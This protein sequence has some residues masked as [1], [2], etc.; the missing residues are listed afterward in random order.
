LSVDNE[1]GLDDA[2]VH[3]QEG[4]LGF[5]GGLVV[6]FVAGLLELSDLTVNNLGTLSRTDTVAED[7]D[8]SGEGALVFSGED[9]DSL[10]HAILDLRVDYLLS[11]LLDDKVRVI[12]RHLLVS[13]GG[14]ADNRVA[15]RVAHVDTNQHSFHGVHL[16]REFE[17]VEVTSHFGVDLLQDVGSLRKIELECVPDSNDLGGDLVRLVQLLVLVVDSLVSKNHKE[18]LWVT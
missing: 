9:I 16:L 3:D 2:L 4:E 13:G 10:L 7:D 17:V 8:V 12:L 15:S 18:H 1:E 14:K 5:A 6:A 11:L